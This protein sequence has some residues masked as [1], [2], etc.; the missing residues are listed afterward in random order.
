[1]TLTYKP[2]YNLFPNDSQCSDAPH[3]LKTSTRGEKTENRRTV[4]LEA[5]PTEAENRFSK[6]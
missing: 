4:A 2:L 3:R 5:V 1:M 6:V